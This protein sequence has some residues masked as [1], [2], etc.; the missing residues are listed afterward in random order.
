MKLML[1]NANIKLNI[2]AKQNAG[3]SNVSKIL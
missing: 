2:M 3:L 1:V